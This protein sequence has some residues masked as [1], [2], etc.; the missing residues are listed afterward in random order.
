[1]APYSLN[2]LLFA[3]IFFLSP[4]LASLSLESSKI[5]SLESITKYLV[6]LNATISHFLTSLRE[7]SSPYPFLISFKKS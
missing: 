3:S 1:M 6:P 4:G 2:I 7:K 5:T